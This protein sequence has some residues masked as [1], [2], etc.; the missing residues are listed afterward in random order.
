V[1]RVDFVQSWDS[2]MGHNS[3]VRFGFSFGGVST[4]TVKNN[5]T[6]SEW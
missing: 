1:L 2:Y 5:P 4:T 6:G 3:G